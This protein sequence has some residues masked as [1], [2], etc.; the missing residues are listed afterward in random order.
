MEIL[1]NFRGENSKNI[2]SFTTQKRSIDAVLW[3]PEIR[4]PLAPVEGKVVEIPSFTKFF[5]N[6][7]GGELS[8]NFSTSTL[9]SPSGDAIDLLVGPGKR[10]K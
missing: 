6:F 10:V 5:F 2:W 9:K 4:D 3:Q 1:P 7:P 8:P